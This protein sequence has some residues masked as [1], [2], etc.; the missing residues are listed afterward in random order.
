MVF[1]WAGVHFLR[2][3]SSRE[4]SL[5]HFSHTVGILE[6]TVLSRTLAIARNVD[7]KELSSFTWKYYDFRYLQLLLH[8]WHMVDMRTLGRWKQILNQWRFLRFAQ[9]NDSRINLDGFIAII[10]ISMLSTDQD[11]YNVEPTAG[12][13]LPQSQLDN[14]Y[15]GEACMWGEQVSCTFLTR[16][17]HIWNLKLIFPSSEGLPFVTDV[18]DL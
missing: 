4:S 18:S 12:L 14:L 2:F 15:G 6:R 9:D 11:F 16:I 1:G 8:Q 17:S 7:S 3:L 10:I 5:S 13:N